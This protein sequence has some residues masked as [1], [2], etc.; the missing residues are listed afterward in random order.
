MTPFALKPPRWA[1]LIF[2]AGIGALIVR[3]LLDSR[4]ANSALLYVAVPFLVSFLLFQ[5]TPKPKNTSITLRYLSHIR[6][7]TIVMLATSAFLFEGFLCVLFFMPIYYLIITINFLADLFVNRG[8]GKDRSKLRASVIPLFIAVLAIEG[9]TPSTSFERR[10]EVTRTAIVDLS[11]D[12]LKANM[13]LP[14]ALPKK[15]NWL[16][17]IFPLPVDVQAGS[18]KPGDVH[19]LKFVYKRWFFTNIQEGRFD[20]RIDAVEPTEVR[21]SVV[22]N[23]SY[24]AKYLKIKKTRVVFDPLSDGR[25]KVSLTIQYNR[26]LDPAWYF[27]PMQQYAVEQSG[28]YFI[29]SVFIR[30]A[31]HE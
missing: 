23:T 14:I 10:N 1:Y 4:F 8:G 28:D 25:T 18:L 21:T 17:S 13:A 20:L 12:E 7:A 30:G 26:L 9:V 22:S 27:A 6:D 11:I 2:L 16:L 5:F 19:K 3:T 15:R 24:L 29:S 31:D